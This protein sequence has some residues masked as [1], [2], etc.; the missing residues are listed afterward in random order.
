MSTPY[1]WLVKICTNCYGHMA[2]MVATPIYGKIFKYL[3]WNQNDNSLGTYYVALVMW[4]L[5]VCTND[6]SRFTLTY[7]MARSNLIPNAFITGKS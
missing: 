4:S 1:D 2:K 5:P 6:E 7:F 3:L